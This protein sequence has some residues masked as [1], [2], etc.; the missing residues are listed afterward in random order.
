MPLKKSELY[1]S[2]WKSCDELRGGMDASQY[3]DYVLVMLFVK[4]VSDKYA[5]QRNPLIVVPEGGGFADMVSLKGSKDIGDKMNKIIGELAAANDL[6]G[7]IDTADFN[8]ADKLGRG[9]E[10][11][12]R[13]SNL[14]AIFEDPGLDF[15]RN[16][17]EGDDLLG[18]AYEYL[19]RNFATESGKSKGQFYTPAEVSRIMAKVIGVSNASSA[20]TTIYDPACGSG[21]LLLKAADEAQTKITIYGQEKDNATRALARM[22]MI[23]HDHPAAE[24]WQDNTLS[25]PHYK[26]KDGSLKRFDFVVANP[27]FSYKAWRSGFDPEND[28]YGRFEDGVPPQKNG[29]YA[30]LQHLLRSM[31]STAKGAIILPH[32]VLFR[33]NVEGDI[34]RN[35]VRKG[36]IQGIIG[37]P[38]NLFYG[39]GIPACIL[40]LN[41]EDAAER[42]GIYMINA[43]QGF[44]KDGNKNR[45]R[46]QDIQKIVDV[47]Q[48][49]LEISGYSRMVPL[50]EISDPKNDFNLNI[51]RYIDNSEEE[52]L[53]DIEAHLRGGIPQRD[54][55][56][57]RVYWDVFPSLGRD[58]F[59]DD[60]PG[61]AQLRIPAAQIKGAILDHT[62]FEAYKDEVLA[63][64]ADWQ[65]RSRPALT[66]LE[67]GAS[68][69]ALI[70][71]LGAD[72]LET[73]APARLID[74]YD[75]YQHLMRYWIE[76]LQDDVYLIVDEGWEQANKLRLIKDENGKSKEKEDIKIGKRKYKS[77]LIPPS[78]IIARY[79]SPEK[80]ALQALEA[81]LD[82]AVSQLDELE[83][84]HGSDEGALSDVGNKTEAKNAWNEAL[85]MAW[86]Q[87]WPQTYRAYQTAV[88]DR[89][90]L[91]T[92]LT[93]L[94]DNPR[95]RALENKRG[96]ITLGNVRQ[97][98]KATADED[99]RQLLETYLETYARLRDA[100]S[101]TKSE[102]NQAAQ[103]ITG[104]LDREPENELLDDLQ[105]IN[106]YLE[107][108]DTVSDLKSQIKAA[109][110]E[111]DEKVIQQYQQLSE[112][113]IKTLVVDDK[114]LATLTAEVQG[115]LERVSQALSGRI[116]ELAA[117]YT[118][119][120]PQLAQD[121]DDLASNVAAHLEKM[122]FAWQ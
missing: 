73:F 100:K 54:I 87:L 53:Q 103:N 83:E 101:T 106:T 42:K 15:S 109:Q 7:V 107:L 19:M 2:I 70:A 81:E 25:N 13:L 33:G 110:K 112:D 111:L 43:S 96:N 39:T 120:L 56:S 44:E 108:T 95:L 51:P 78:L 12:D 90:H 41:K 22:N 52:D 5:G 99:E 24:I 68:P 9:K 35:L 88:T 97:R 113:E 69:K 86:E 27:P 85:E 55:E 114:W 3:K 89:D 10:M 67:V 20:D 32:G 104:I 66:G 76:T 84:E 116:T 50:A 118:A 75:V 61:Y 46:H 23:L 16:R 58:L 122:G 21:S 17:A 18:D 63:R 91:N 49:Q 77:D 60:R 57:L 11:Q 47:W 28:L 38:A 36:Y 82:G 115:E 31:K 98:V 121:V 74:K 117:R 62:E 29:D 26:E 59:E 34:R 64:F 72:L 65:S 8:D 45:L 30:F 102:L 71:A 14:V 105:I 37:L 119:P 6:K 40:V 94:Q 48:G 92:Q 1:S 79:F 4:Y 93:K 80:Q